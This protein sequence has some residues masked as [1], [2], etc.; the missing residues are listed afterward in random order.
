MKK[1]LIALTACGMTLIGSSALALQPYVTGSV[2]QTDFDA[3]AGS[4][5]GNFEDEDRFLSIG[6]GLRVTENLAFEIS[7]NDFGTAEYDYA[8]AGPGY[9][10]RG[11]ERIEI[12]SVS[13]AAIGTLPL[14]PSF[15]LFAKIGLD[16]WDAQWKDRFTGVDA[17]G[18]FTGSDKLSDDGADVFFGL[19]AVFNVTANADITV[20]YQ[21]R[22]FDVQGSAYDDLDIDYDIDADVFSVGFSYRF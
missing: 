17:E 20:E 12:D 3:G 19:G 5:G 9:R 7:Y 18:R 8:G 21:L 2:G 10:F 14:A 6:V 22:Q 16:V 15:G 11:T 13:I 1:S 4:S